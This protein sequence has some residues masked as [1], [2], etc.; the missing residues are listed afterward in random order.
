MS[1]STDLFIKENLRNVCTSGKVTIPE[2]LLKNTKIKKEDF[3]VHK[4]VRQN[5]I[6]FIRITIAENKQRHGSSENNVCKFSYDNKPQMTIPVSIRKEFDLDIKDKI[7]F[8]LDTENNPCYIIKPDL[9][10][11]SL[12]TL[13]DNLTHV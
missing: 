7:L 8:F 2:T 4:R 13:V 1:I 3:V 6:T 11:K 5:G 12:Y 10:P 9:E